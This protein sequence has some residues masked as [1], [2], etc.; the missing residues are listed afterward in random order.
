[1]GVGGQ[2]HDPAALP[3]ERPCTHCTG[4]WV[5][6][7]TGMNRCG[8]PRPPPA[9]D[10]RNVQPVASRYTDCAISAHQELPEKRISQ[11]QNH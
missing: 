6:P 2:R 8:K 11:Q 10:P 7:R 9:F 4:G 1:M 5:G 3:R